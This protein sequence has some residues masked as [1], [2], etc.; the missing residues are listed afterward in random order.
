MNYTDKIIL[1][2]EDEAI[3]AKLSK[4]ILEKYGFEVIHT[5]SGEKA[6]HIVRTISRIDLILMDI[7]L[8]DG[9]DGTQAAGLILQQHDIPLVFLSSHTEYEIVK[10]SESITSYGYIVKNTGETVLIASIKMA[11]RLFDAKKMEEEKEKKLRESEERYRSIFEN[12][13]TSMFLVEKNMAIAMVNDDFVQRFGYT[14]EEATGRLKWTDII[15][16][17]C[18]SHMIRQ[19]NL[20]RV[21]EQ[22]A[23]P[24]YEL[25][26]KTK[27]GEIRD[28]YITVGMIPGTDNSIAS[29]TDLTEQK[30]AELLIKEKN[31]EL[32]AINEELE[33]A[34]EEL[35]QTLNQLEE[36]DNEYKT[37]FETSSSG[38]LI[39]IDGKIN[40][41][42]HAVSELTGYSDEELINR[43]LISFIH[44]DDIELV[45]EQY[46]RLLKAGK[47]EISV[48]LRIISSG[49][50]IKWIGIKSGLIFWNGKRATLNFVSDITERKKAEESLKTAEETYRNMFMNSQV[51]IFRTNIDYGNVIEANDYFARLFG[52]KDREHMLAESLDIRDFYVDTGVR[53]RIIK[54]LISHGE[55]NNYNVQ[56][57]RSDS[58]IIWTR[59]SAKLMPEKGYVQGVLI[60]ITEQKNA[61]N[62]LKISEYKYRRIFENAQ[63]L[64]FRTSLDGI[65]LELSPSIKNY[66]GFT[67]E[68]L[69][70]KQV[71]DLYYDPAERDRFVDDIL[72]AEK[73][74]DY[75]LCLQAKDNSLIVTSISSQIYTDPESS[76]I[77][78]EGSI[79]NITKRKEAE[80]A[81][82]REKERLAGVIE[83]TNAGSWEWDI[84][85]G[86][87]VVNDRWAL[88]IG[89]TLE[90]LTPVTI[91]TWRSLIHPEDLNRCYEL[92]QKHSRKEIDYYEAELRI[93]H[94]AGNW[95][96][97]LERG[98]ITKRDPDGRPVLMMGTRLDISKSKDAEQKIHRINR[99]K[100]MYLA[101]ISHEIRTPLSVIT[102]MIDLA[103]AA[104]N[105]NERL[106][107]INTAKQ[108]SS[109]LISLINDVLDYSKIEAG[110]LQLEFIPF[111]PVAEIENVIRIF[112]KICLA[113]K[114]SLNFEKVF[115]KD[116]YVVC[117]D[118][119]RFRQILINLIGN[120]VK[121]TDSGSISVIAEY[122]LNEDLTG[123][124]DSV[125]L[126]VLIRD[127]GPGIPSEKLDMIFDNFVQAD[128]SIS[129]RY[130]GTGLGLAI[131]K[132]LVELMGG[133]INVLTKDGVGSLFNVSIPFRKSGALLNPDVDQN[134]PCENKVFFSILLAED[135]EFNKK[136]IKANLEKAGNRIITAGNG[137]DVIEELQKNNF[138]VILMDIEMPILD[139]Y[140]TTMRI[141][142][143]EAGEKNRDIPIIALSA[144]STSEISEYCLNAG[145]NGVLVKPVNLKVLYSLINSLTKTD[146]KN[147]NQLSVDK[148]I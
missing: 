83:G 147:I 21:D 98:K 46:K 126:N 109:H 118:P 62:A 74:S 91:E 73:V 50:I 123:N 79:H 128:T 47:P 111:A 121:F 51:G 97:V 70:G 29:I 107:C 38:I 115:L 86:E 103:L 5:D 101:R 10:K 87:F 23:L 141:R 39:E 96:W 80:K 92:I 140:E 59:F 27:S 67:R 93:R 119:T 64:F 61:E 145:M 71:R 13:G 40:V 88:M 120:A 25:R 41:F 52:F 20:R 12:T 53:D 139:G 82:I 11:F 68:E 34:N 130:G 76:E 3:N 57:R 99:A 35:I 124:T 117:G 100:S 37:L 135:N 106:D 66:S 116:S 4:R 85:T 32:A 77:I 131:S 54:N 90:N 108:A 114:L 146:S 84:L 129:S 44:P 43:P 112:D 33:A 8:G 75:E 138:D 95:I 22:T 7:D 26:Y 42:N 6:I 65:I 133:T 148:N 1:L 102:G 2:V 63:D 142:I 137:R 125:L 19:H 127:T 105:E 31:E 110:A 24:G 60:D 36:R 18:I 30:K 17:D 122:I 16:P 81:L 134:L 58:S 113:K 14:K 48:P 136:M 94:M 15:H 132:E 144:H 9:I 69:I 49:N 56:F 143:G 78:I 89:N 104:D 55:L 28:A 72:S 45:K